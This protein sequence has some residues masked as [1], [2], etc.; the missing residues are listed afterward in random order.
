MTSIRMP[1][2]I[3]YSKL[4]LLIV[5][6]TW[7]DFR[8]YMLEPGDVEKIVVTNKNTARVYLRPGARGVPHR[9]HHPMGSAFGSRQPPGQARTNLQE[10][11]G[12]MDS[13]II[14]IAQ[15]EM[16]MGTET[17]SS[18]NLSGQGLNSHAHQNQ[19]VYHFSIGSVE[20]FERKLEEAQRE[21]GIQ[22]R[23]F[24]P[25]QYST[26]TS[27]GTELLKLV[28]TFFL[29]G[30]LFFLMRNVGGAAGSGGGGGMSNIFKIGKSPAKKIK[31]EDI[32]VTFADVAGCDEAK[33]EIMEFVDFLKDSERFTKL[34]AKIPKGALL[35]G[36]PVSLI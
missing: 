28:P 36:P 8:N 12:G 13:T 14:S 33:K 2:C 23:D 11:W 31:K 9:G 7:S 4:I 17:A 27:W 21:L 25:V 22:P 32:N 1:F 20:S 26:E 6:V 29:L 10:P 15:D 16:T 35:C 30:M 3:Y 19:L 18:R 34:G 5:Q 24:V